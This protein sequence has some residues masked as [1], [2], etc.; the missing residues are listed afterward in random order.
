MLRQGAL[1]GGLDISQ[2]DKRFAGF[3]KDEKKLDAEVHRKYIYRGHLADYT[4]V[5]WILF[6]LFFILLS[7]FLKKNPQ[8]FTLILTLLNLF[9]AT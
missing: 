9:L 1:D 5:S 8:V 3:K 2:S 6:S 4:R 7:F